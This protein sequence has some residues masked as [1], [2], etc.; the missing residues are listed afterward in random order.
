MVRK[1]LITFFGS[2]FLPIAPGTWGSLAAAVVF[3][4]LAVLL[5]QDHSTL[6]TLTAGLTILASAIG[7]GLGRWAVE[8]FHSEDPKPFVL[9]EVAGQWLALIAIPFASTG[10]LFLVVVVQ[11]FLFRFF[12]ILKPT[13]ARQAESLPFGWGIVTDD[14]VAGLYANITGQILF[15]VLLV[16]LLPR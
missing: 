16:H 11:F 6:W 10:G 13:P 9:D 8:Y 7:I 15:R 14:L 4:P 12:D 2:G 1:L 3:L 5:G